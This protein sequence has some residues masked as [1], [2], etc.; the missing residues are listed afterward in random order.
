M[1]KTIRFDRSGKKLWLTVG[2]SFLI[3][4]VALFIASRYTNPAP[5]SRIVIS[6]GSE[7]DY[8]SYAELYK[9]IIKKSG[10]ALDVRPS[11]GTRENLAL[12]KDPKSDVEVAFVQDGLDVDEESSNLVSLGSLYY[13]PLWVFYR[14]KKELTR[15]SQLIGK[16]VVIGE[17]GGGGPALAWRLLK[18]SGVD[19]NNTRFLHVGY[20]DAAEALKK[21]EADAAFFLATPEDAMVKELLADKDVRLMN[22]DQAEAITRH[23]PY[24]HH[25]VL[26]HGSIDLQKNIPDQDVHLVSPTA[27]LVARSSLNPA[28]IDLLLQAATEVHSEPGIFEKKGEFPVDKDYDFPL[29]AEAKRYYKSGAPF[30]Q[31]YLPFWLATLVDRFILLVVPLLALIV[32]AIRMIPKYFDWRVRSR[33]YKRYGELKYL[34][35]QLK[36]ETNR[37]KYAAHLKELDAI[38]ERVNHMKL[39]IEFSEH[40]YVLREHIDFVRGKLSRGLNVND[41]AS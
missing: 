12:L 20:A 9:D 37:D 22:V 15:F 17:H 6:A 41:K 7:G 18:V 38:E 19:K 3:L 36:A 32:P 4:V 10:V 21:G 23:M 11:K 2:S 8:Q 26:P 33:I 30:W 13:E 35:T 14:G 1:K 28:L 31:R 39:P 27:T 16:R 5:P 25:L 29:S 34:E 24:L 40:R